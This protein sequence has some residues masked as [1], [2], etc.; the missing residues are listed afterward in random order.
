MR[1]YAV[2]VA[3]LMVSTLAAAELEDG[4]YWESQEADAAEYVAANGREVFLGKKC[5]LKVT[6]ASVRAEDNTNET[7]YVQVELPYDERLTKDKRLSLVVAKR[8]HAYAG[9]GHEDE[10]RCWMEFR[11][12]GKEHADTVAK[13]FNTQTVVRQHPGHRLK[14]EFFAEKKSY[15]A[16]NDVL[17]Q[18]RIQNVGDKPVA[19]KSGGHNR[20]A[21]DTQFR[22]SAYLDGESVKDIGNNLSLGGLST[23]VTLQPGKSFVDSVKLNDWFKLDKPGYYDVLGSYLMEYYDPEKPDDFHPVW[24]DIVSAEFS[25]EVDTAEKKAAKPLKSDV[26]QE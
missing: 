4:L 26:K 9:S 15:A 19:F 24:N 5:D 10:K 2:V 18:L 3:A 25:F 17:A 21:R 12:R 13:F 6:S 16:G 14:V 22:F 11:V 7:F 1:L 8:V 23:V 20:A